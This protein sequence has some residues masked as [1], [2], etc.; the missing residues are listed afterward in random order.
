MSISTKVIISTSQRSD[1]R[2]RVLRNVCRSLSNRKSVLFIATRQ[3][4]IVCA[5]VFDS[6]G[7]CREQ[8]IVDGWVKIKYNQ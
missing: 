8:L 1:I 7:S 4:V 6:Q 3:H 5:F 2:S